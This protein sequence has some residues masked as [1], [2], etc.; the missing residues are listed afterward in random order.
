MEPRSLGRCRQAVI[1]P[2]H[3]LRK[4]LGLGVDAL[5]VVAHALELEGLAVDFLLVSGLLELVLQVPDVLDCVLI[6]CHA[7]VFDLTNHVFELKAVLEHVMEVD[8]LELL[9][10]RNLLWGD[11]CW[12]II[13]YR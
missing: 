12:G 8:A 5:Q 11:E 7:E 6:D 3:G 10:H 13:V 4:A 9:K 2:A 1:E